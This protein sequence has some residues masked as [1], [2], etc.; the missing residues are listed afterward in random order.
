MLA[1]CIPEHQADFQDQISLVQEVIEDAGHLCIFLPEFHCELNSIEFFWGAVKRWL[2]EN[3]KYT[4]K[5]LQENLPEA[6]QSVEL[7]TIQK[8]EH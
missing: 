8:W 1:K 7:A 2:R 3:C 4:F 5:T 6:L